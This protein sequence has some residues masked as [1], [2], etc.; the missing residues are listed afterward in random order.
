MIGNYTVFFYVKRRMG[1]SLTIFGNFLITRVLQLHQTIHEERKQKTDRK[2]RFDLKIKKKRR[3]SITGLNCS[4]NC[5]EK[6]FFW[7]QKIKDQKIR[8]GCF[9]YIFSDCTVSV[10]V[11]KRSSYFYTM[12]RSLCYCQ[13]TTS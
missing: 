4:R 5:L 7:H 8:R 9:V 1:V 3:C 11:Y 12:T 2:E 10:N 13:V 6:L